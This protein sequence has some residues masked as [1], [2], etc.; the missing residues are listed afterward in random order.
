MTMTDAWSAFVRAVNDESAKLCATHSHCVYQR[1]LIDKDS[2]KK[3]VHEISMCIH[4]Y[5][6]P[7][8]KTSKWENEFLLL[9]CFLTGQ[10]H[11]QTHG[12]IHAEINAQ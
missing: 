12:W 6:S 1:G 3:I 11:R 9:P 8:Y 10:T 5:S 7:H 2:E 4:T